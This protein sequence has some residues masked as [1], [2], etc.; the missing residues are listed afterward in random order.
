[1]TTSFRRTDRD[2]VEARGTDADL[3]IVII[4]RGSATSPGSGEEQTET[5][6]R[7]AGRIAPTGQGIDLWQPD[8]EL[9]GFITRIRTSLPDGRTG[10]PSPTHTAQHIEGLLL[11]Y[12]QQTGT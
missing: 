3:E 10:W 9:A 1:M 5:R 4:T 8:E 11:R 7:T 12:R 6:T 2:R